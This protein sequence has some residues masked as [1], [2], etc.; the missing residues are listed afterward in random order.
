MTGLELPA[1]LAIVGTAAAVAG[2]ATSVVGAVQQ[3]NAQR[4]A[5]QA[6]R[7]QQELQRKAVL[8]QALEAAS[9]N[10][11]ADLARK[12]QEA[13]EQER[14]RR[15]RLQALGVLENR[16]GASMTTGL[17]VDSVFSNL[18]QETARQDDIFNLNSQLGNQSAMYR[19]QDLGTQLSSN[20]NQLSRPIEGVSGLTTA[21]NVG[22]QLVY[23]ASNIASGIG[24]YKAINA[25]NQQS[26]RI[27]QFYVNQYDNQIQSGIQQ[28]GVNIFDPNAVPSTRFRS[29]DI[30]Y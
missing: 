25:T 6:A 8:K 27:N 7:E 9:R 4:S 26:D 3:G 5:A 23:G 2:T 28:T 17:S 29:R 20:L 14:R 10:N 12:E 16:S 24:N 21:L 15:E 19:N 13:V 18:L 1:I 22:G 30:G 11:Q